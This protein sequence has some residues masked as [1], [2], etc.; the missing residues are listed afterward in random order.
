MKISDI[1]EQFPQYNDLSDTALA[2]ALHSKY[3]PDLP[4]EDVY[5]QLGLETSKK[6]LGAAFERGLESYLSP[7]LTALQG[8]STESALAGVERARHLEETNPSQTSLEKVKEAFK[9]GVL[10]GIGETVREIPYAFAEQAPNLVSMGAGARLGAMA[11]APFGGVGALGGAGLGALAGQF[12]SSYLPQAGGNIEEQAQA[13]KARGEPVNINALKAYG[14]AVP[15]AAA[16]VGLMHYIGGRG[17]MGKM[18][19]VPEEL[20]AKKSAVEVEKLAQEKLVPSLLKG[21]AKGFA[22]EVPTEILQDVLQ[23]AQAG[24][25]L[26]SPEAFQGYGETAF[27]MGLLSPLGALGRLSEKSEARGQLETK[28]AEEQKKQ[29]IQAIKDQQTADAQEEQRK[30][31]PAYMQTFVQNYEALQDQYK[32]LQ[33]QTKKPDMK[34]AVPADIEQYNQNREQLAEMRKKLTAD[35]QEYLQLRP[36]YNKIRAQQQTQAQQAED[37]RYQQMETETA[38]N[39]PTADTAYYQSPQGTLPGIQPAIDP[40]T[41]EPVAQAPEKVDTRALYDRLQ[42]LQRAKDAHQQ[43]ES[44]IAASGDMK[45]LG[46]FFKQK[47]TVDKAYKDTAKQLKEAGGYEPA[48]K[49]PA[50]VA[51]DAYNKA[52]AELQ[53]KSKAGTFGYDP[54]V[55]RKLYAKVEAAQNNLDSVIAEHGPAPRGHEQEGFDFG[56][57]SKFPELTQESIPDFVKRRNDALVAERKKQAELYEQKIRPEIQGIQR[58]ASRRDEGPTI[59]GQ[60]PQME[61]A[62]KKGFGSAAMG[63]MQQNLEGIELGTDLI[64]TAE[65]TQA[66][67][68]EKSPTEPYRGLYASP[69]EEPEFTRERKEEMR[70]DLERRLASVMS[71]Y[72]MPQG[73]YDMLRRAEN[74]L[75]VPN[76]DT[77]FMRTLDEQLKEIE[78]GRE[79]MPRKGAALPTEDLR[80]F[81]LGETAVYKRFSKEAG[82]AGR[83]ILRGASAKPA[84]LS[85]QAE[86]EEHLRTS[87]AARGEG[88]IKEKQ[89]PLFP[90]ETPNLFPETGKTINLQEELGTVRANPAQFQRFLNSDK[91]KKLRLALDKDLNELQKLDVIDQLKT[92]ADALAKEVNAME[93]VNLEYGQAQRTLRHQRDVGKQRHDVNQLRQAMFSGIIRRMGLQNKLDELKKAKNAIDAEARANHI[94]GWDGFDPDLHANLEHM[95]EEYQ[96]AVN[97]MAEMQG[98][99]STL[100]GRL[101]VEEAKIKIAKLNPLTTPKDTLAAAKEELNAA[102]FDLGEAQKT[103]NAELVAN[104]A[105]E[106]KQRRADEAVAKAKAD[107]IRDDIAKE[108]QERLEAAYNPATRGVEYPAILDAQRMAKELPAQ[109]RQPTT[110]AEEQAIRGNPMKVLGG[111]KSDVTKLEKKIQQSQTRSKNARLEGLSELRNNADALNKQYKESAT[112]AERAELLPK[113]EAA[114]TAYDEEVNKLVDQPITWIGMAKDIRDLAVAINRA[115]RLEARI[116]SGDVEIQGVLPAKQRKAPHKNIKRA[117][118]TVNGIKDKIAIEKDEAEKAKL[119]KR[120][121]NAE[122]FLTTAKAEEAQRNTQAAKAAQETAGAAK[123]TEPALTKSEVKK[124]TKQGNTVYTSKGVGEEIQ[125]KIAKEVKSKEIVENENKYKALKAKKPSTLNA[126]EKAFIQMYEYKYGGKSSGLADKILAED[127]KNI[128]FSRGATVNGLTKSELQKELERAFGENIVGRKKEAQPS[129][130]LDIFD[131]VNDYIKTLPPAKATKMESIIPKDAKGFVK[132]GKAILFANNI[133]KGHGIGVLLHEVG[134]HIGFRNF[135]DAPQYKALVNTVKSWAKRTDDSIEARVGRAAMDRVKMANTPKSQI[136]DELLAYAVEEASQMGVEPAGV[137]GGEA[138]AN[139]LRI[140]VDAFKKALATFGFSPKELTAGDMVNFAYGCANLELKGTWHGTAVKFDAFD[141]AYMGTGEGAQAFGWGTYRAQQKGI[142]SGYVATALQSHLRDWEERPEIQQWKTALQTTYDGKDYGAI[143]EMGYAHPARK[144]GTPS[145]KKQMPTGAANI[146]SSALR[147]DTN[148]RSTADRF[149]FSPRQMI[150][151]DIKDSLKVYAGHDKAETEKWFKD[152]FDPTKIKGIHDEPVYQGYDSLDQF[153][154]NKDKHN[155][156][157]HVLEALKRDVSTEAFDV[158]IKNAIEKAKEELKNTIALFDDDIK[159]YLYREAKTLLEEAKTF[160]PKEVIFNQK[161]A[162][163]IPKPEGYLTRTLHT[164]PENEYLHWNEETQSEY[165]NNRIQKLYDSLTEKQKKDFDAS[166]KPATHKRV[167]THAPVPGTNKVRIVT[168]KEIVNP[169]GKDIYNA[170]SA[171]FGYKKKKTDK[172]VSEKLFSLGVPGLKFLDQPSRSSNR[173]GISETYNYVDF[174]DKEEGAQIVAHN[175]NPIGQAKGML[176]SIKPKYNNAEFASVGNIADKFI[177]KE[178]TLLDKVKANATGL[179]VETQLV[180]RFAGFERLSKTMDELKGSQMMFYLRMYDQRMNFV[181]QS[182]ANGALG[183]AEKTRADGRKEYLIESKPGPSLKSTVEILKEASPL[184]GNGE[185]VNRLFTLYMSAIRAI[186]KGFEAL[187]FGNN[188]TEAELKQAKATIDATPELKDIF[189]RARHE[190]NTYNRNQLEFAAQAGAI[191][192]DVVARLLK[193]NDYIPW[194]RQRNGVAELVIGSETPIRVG[195]IAEQPYLQELVGG[196]TPILDFVTSSVQNTNMIADMGLRNLATKNAVF[197]LVDMDLAHISKKKLAGADVVKFKVDGEDRYAIID[198]DKVGIP[199]DI[200]VKGMEGIPAQM[201]FAFRVMG[202]PA[203]LL[204]KVVTASP[205]YAAKQLFRDSLAATILSGADFTPVMGSLKEINSAT[206]A[207]LEQRGITGGQ[208]FTGT[209]EDLSKILK[210][211]VN[212][213]PGWLNSLSKWEAMSMEADAT[214]RRAQYNS[215]IQQGLSEM[216]ATLMSLESMNFNKRGASPS[217]HI[218][219]S[220]IPF[221]NAQIQSL[222]VLYKALTG[223]LPFNEKLKIQEKLLVR[224]AMLAAGTLAYTMMM[225]DDDAYKNATP[226]QKYNNWFVRVPGVDEPVRLPIPFEIGYIFKALPEALYNTMVNKHGK[227]E[228]VEA[229]SGIM[230]NLIPGG[231]SYGIPQALKP[232]IEAG[233]GKSFYTGRDILTKTE[234]NLLPEDQFRANTTEA[235][236]AFGKATGTSPIIMEELVRGYTGTLGLAFLQAVSMGVPKG[237]TPEQTAGRLSELP[238]VGGA[239]QPNDAGGIISSVYKRMDDIKKVANTVD[240]RLSKG[241]KAEALDLIHRTGN[242]Y[243]ASEVADYYTSTM[244]DLTSYENAIRASNMTGEQKREKLDYIRQMKIKF[245]NSVRNATDKIALQ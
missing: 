58:I 136:D 160:N 82:E 224:G 150:E 114:E 143:K 53:E 75:A 122:K 232:A 241:Q 147:N 41:G 101:K 142:A 176:F 89:L 7:S 109:E 13:Q 105:E 54:E 145:P 5:K 91:V 215:Y 17:L 46:E 221:F 171:A 218:I 205:L 61:E 238:V 99:L 193:E 20:M 161:S 243:A 124:A 26:T 172:T 222:N 220:L 113:L 116:E 29:Q 188:L 138:V 245:A 70:A 175:I 168:N 203:K 80:A 94:G 187:H 209:N 103:A 235:A 156:A 216:E 57:E 9:K 227:E 62:P 128:E 137:K 163:P 96:R 87:E 206:K 191:S 166:L 71:R 55:A 182:V 132:D 169:Q 68:A 67:N 213:K 112:S 11:G 22:A 226:D 73:T 197:E 179:A 104:K 152:N 27:Q 3:Y 155:F 230:K 223:K 12:V 64:H 200:L 244:K 78:S 81:P 42:I 186:D 158:K 119:E 100:E 173:K 123:T 63:Q 102:R 177:A 15:M 141:H 6:G 174:S 56:P 35:S 51:Q 214:T 140:M 115:D 130:V 93:S 60:L 66:R 208:I 167:I 126:M 237:D 185:A 47:D 106:G 134:V 183:I 86:L 8:P 231:S 239:F 189:D 2:D 83:P 135:F 40:T 190:Y 234:Q 228:A 199:A 181:A 120:L 44:E 118:K 25:D 88:P 76:P 236:K 125:T 98:A 127:K 79:G 233:L 196:D 202:I 65:E 225:Q 240:E 31:D 162:Y 170:F 72:E 111:Y 45:A 217:V 154:N 4:K 133:G 77:D 110:N 50:V 36:A 184:V 92:R 195:S 107:K 139:W 10:P 52:A 34:T 211:I 39:Q 210:D 117:E 108:R 151:D 157:Y 18:L 33:K 180:D 121:A 23:R 43:Q 32:D 149:V 48:P 219:N 74:A 159:H 21:T 16:D 24:E 14:T 30:Q 129:R 164:R 28:K 90:G 19:G 1:R 146:L 144:D 242:A 69:T 198:T 201:P 178:K 165:V 84:P 204:R 85:R 59:F 229:F 148:Y 207:T 194:Y 49:H 38:Q 131:S 95:H 153:S 192:K 212:N 97:E 37:Q